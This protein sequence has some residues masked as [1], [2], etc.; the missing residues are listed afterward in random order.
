MIHAM[1]LR[2]AE[3]TEKLAHMRRWLLQAQAG[4]IRL[5][6]V[7]W[8]SWATAGGL[9]VVLLGAET[10]AAQLLITA[11]HAYVLTDDIEVQRLQDEEVPPGWDWHVS[12]W[13]EPDVRERFVA[14]LAAGAAVI[15]DRPMA[16]ENPLPPWCQ[17]ERLV[18]SSQEQ[19]RLRAVGQLAASAMLEVM[20]AARPGWSEFALAG[21]GAEA[22]WGRG[23]HPVLTLAA[24]AR[25]LPKYRHPT[26][27]AATLG[28]EAM[29][30]LCA[31]GFGLVVSLTRFAEFAP[32]DA[33]QRRKQ[34]SLRKIE[35]A[36][37]QASCAGQPLSGVYHAF[38]Q[39][40]CAEG[41]P[42]AIREHHQGGIAGYLPREII[43][44]ALS[45]HVLAPGMALAFNPS[46]PGS[47]IED[48][49]LLQA[50][51]L[52]NLTLDSTWP[53][54]KEQG[55]LRPLPLDAA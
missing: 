37:L 52:E 25:R 18:L 11:H 39:A 24:G 45:K 1:H 28:N 36:G 7:D 19:Q 17:A 6:G 21:A 27:S 55:R 15:S 47:K 12:A 34:A 10:G 22:L 32:P 3:V 33:Q 14:D 16:G 53:S 35:A 8:F 49:F 5:R 40:Y 50:E 43:A 44:T 2:H 42:H 54:T 13:A 31:R 51:Q 20:H 38:A 48:T 30:V 23:L 9:D 41:Y 29:L 46:L 26:P 4:A